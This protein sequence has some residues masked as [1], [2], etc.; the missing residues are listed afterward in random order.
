MEGFIPGYIVSALLLLLAAHTASDEN[1]KL[2]WEHQ[3]C[4]HM[5]RLGMRLPSTQ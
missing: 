3:A 4:T 5:Y 2:E 1:C